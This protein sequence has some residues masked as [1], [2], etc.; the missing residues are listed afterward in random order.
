MC[1][2]FILLFDGAQSLQT[3]ALDR[4][5]ES[6]Y[7]CY[8]MKL[9]RNVWAEIE[10]DEKIRSQVVLT[11]SLK[12]WIEA[13]RRLTGETLSQYLRRAALLRLLA[14]EEEKKELE[15]LAQL[16]I[17]SISLDKHPEWKTKKSLQKWLKDLRKEWR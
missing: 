13:K 16:I 8:T 3:L 4:L 7:H 11:A 6:V 2:V 15:R 1:F 9:M 10:N 12:Q 17:G 5:L 14:E